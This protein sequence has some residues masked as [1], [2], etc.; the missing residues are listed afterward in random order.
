MV[1]TEATSSA[2]LVALVEADDLE[3]VVGLDLLDARDRFVLDVSDDLVGGRL[4]RRNHRAIHGTCRLQLTR[5]LPWGSARVR[6]RYELTAPSLRLTRAWPM[7]VYVLSTPEHVAGASPATWTVE[8]YDKLQVLDTPAGRTWAAAKDSPVLAEVARVFAEVGETRARIDQAAAAR[9]VSSTRV[10]VLDERTTWLGIVNDL[11]AMV[12]Y[13]A[14]WADRDGTYRC[15]PYVDPSGRAPDWAYDADSPTTAV[16]EERSLTADY[17]AAPNRWVAVRDDPALPTP[18]EGNGI[19]VAVNQSN[20]PTSIDAR[21]RVITRAL[22]LDA[23]DQD[24]LV[25]Q[26]RRYVAEDVR[27]DVAVAMSSSPNPVHWHFSV[28]SY[29]DAALGPDRR[30]VE[31]AWSLPLDGGDM[32][33]EL[34]EVTPA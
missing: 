21:G 23:A 15:E 13:R 14:V 29:R 25:A 3:V 2:Q 16:A 12:G 28:V 10:W 31:D 17:F 5:A 4:E 11:L 9:V 7:G 1:L 18:V 32:S 33:H 8:G 27:L 24:S 19:A 26:L 34:Q 30:L 20:G 6:P 22:R